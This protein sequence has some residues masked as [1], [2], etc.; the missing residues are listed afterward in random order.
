MHER[1]YCFLSQSYRDNNS[2]GLIA[3]GKILCLRG[4]GCPLSVARSDK[5]VVGFWSGASMLKPPPHIAPS[6]VPTISTILARGLHNNLRLISIL[7]PVRL[8]LLCL[9]I[10][11]VFS[12]CLISSDANIS[13]RVLLLI[14]FEGFGQNSPVYRFAA[15][16]TLSV[17]HART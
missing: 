11:D 13:E 16:L 5:K 3:R 4:A 10:S 6:Y 12:F 9:V 14:D 15:M 8:Q 2:C 17:V 7:K 1:L